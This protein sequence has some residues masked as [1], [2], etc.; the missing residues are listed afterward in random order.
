MLQRQKVMETKRDKKDREKQRGRHK[1]I[2]RDRQTQTEIKTD[3]DTGI[4]LT[5][6]RPFCS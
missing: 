5:S 3:R 4:K 1:D 2:N 6:V